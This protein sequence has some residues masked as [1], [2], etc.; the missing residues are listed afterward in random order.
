[1]SKLALN[2]VEQ[3]AALL[4]SL[5]IGNVEMQPILNAIAQNP[6]WLSAHL[7]DMK[8]IVAAMKGRA[9]EQATR[10]LI[11]DPETLRY[12]PPYMVGKLKLL[13][14]DFNAKTFTWRN[15]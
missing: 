8:K 11:S 15:T 5:G 2:E 4:V 9:G 10:V 13:L 1:V 6:K 7:R 12:A 3:F 14:A